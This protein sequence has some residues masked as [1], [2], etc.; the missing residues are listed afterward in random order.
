M[1]YA[2]VEDE[3]LAASRLEKLIKELRPHYSLVGKAESTKRAK[4]LLLRQGVDLIFLDIELS[5]GISLELFESAKIKVPVIFTTAYDQYAL[6]AFKLN[7][8]DYLLKPIDPGELQR[9][10]EKFEEVFTRKVHEPLEPQLLQSLYA[11]ITHKYKER[12]VV[13]IGDHLKAINIEEISA[14]YSDDKMTFIQTRNGHR[15]IVDYTVEHIH[16]LLDPA[17]FFRISRKY[18]IRMDSIKDMLQFTNSR[19][20]LIVEGLNREDVVV[21]REKVQEFKHWLDS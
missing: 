21:A 11:K 14:I 4:E 10:I 19:L 1:N 12:F 7:S 18:I 16:D 3:Q 20:R 13:K 15:F 17:L 6:R 2:I 5:D 9:S 8:V